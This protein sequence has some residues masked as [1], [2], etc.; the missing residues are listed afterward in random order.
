MTSQR[1]MGR[2]L[3]GMKTLALTLLVVPGVLAATFGQTQKTAE[4]FNNRGLERQGQADI[5]GV[6]ADYTQAICMKARASTIAT[7]Y[8]NR[9]NA[10]MGKG[11]FEGAVADYSKA[12]ELQ[13]SDEENYYNRGVAL[14]AKGDNEAAIADFSKPLEM[15]QRLA[16]A[17]N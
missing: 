5:D 7:A 16:P 4:D 9:A 2:R 17:Y 15:S 10:R 12:I 1:L 8:N 14:P 13:P 3:Q 6:I 11:D